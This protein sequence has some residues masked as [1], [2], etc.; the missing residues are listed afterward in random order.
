MK[1]YTKKGDKGETSLIGGKRVL[2]NNMRVEAYGTVDELI[3]SI[4]IVRACRIEKHYKDFILEIQSKLM[5]IAAILATEGDEVKKLP[6]ITKVDVK[7]LENEIDKINDTLPELKK[8]VIP[9]GSLPEAYAH[10]SR[11]ICRRAERV[12]ISLIDKK[13]EIPDI[14]LT[15]INRLSDF[16]FIFARKLDKDKKIAD[17]QWIPKTE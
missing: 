9:G 5:T 16:L 3:S 2:K 15:Y 11:S 13:Y 12:I 10:M 1:V 14:V 17:L 6:K 8:F 4:G 7:K